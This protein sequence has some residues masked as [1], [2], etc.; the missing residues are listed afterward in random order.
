[1]IGYNST[2]RKRRKSIYILPNLF[3]SANM[4]CGFFAIIVAFNFNFILSAICIYLSAFMDTLDGRIA[5]LTNTQSN[6]GA[7]YDSMSDIVSFGVAPAVIVYLWSLK[8]IYQLGLV[9]T[10]IY[11]SCVAL[12]ISRFNV[13]HYIANKDFSLNLR[14]FIG[15][16]CPAAASTIA[17]FVWF[18]NNLGY[19]VGTSW[20][21]F[22]TGI[23]VLYLSALMI[24][25]IN[26]RS[27]KDYKFKCRMS[28]S[29]SSV[30]IVLIITVIFLDPAVILFFI[31][32]IYAISGMF[33]FIY[34]KIYR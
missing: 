20:L 25:N 1:M 32:M 14:Y 18:F 30:L 15:L 3:T 24:S 22:F 23:I 13:D 11:L 17:G 28:F 10:F 31:F 4:L 6:F 8:N 27:F 2:E 21:N 16:P 19:N 29:K 33:S 9:I 34:L 5:R 7:E 12:R 26:F